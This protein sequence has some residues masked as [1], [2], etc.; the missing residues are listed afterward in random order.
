MDGEMGRL[1][2]MIRTFLLS[3][4]LDNMAD[5]RIHNYQVVI[6]ALQ[7]LGAERPNGGIF[8]AGGIEAC[9]TWCPSYWTKVSPSGHSAG[10][11]HPWNNTTAA[12]HRSEAV[13]SCDPHRRRR[14]EQFFVGANATTVLSF[15]RLLHA[16]RSSRPSW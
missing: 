16:T 1:K 5:V 9:V 12:V 3:E 8:K 7:Q 2:N 10:G 11:M 14:E 15:L 6:R 4:N 13:G